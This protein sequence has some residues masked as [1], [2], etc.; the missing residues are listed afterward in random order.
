MLYNALIYPPLL[1]GITSWALTYSS[2][3]D[4][5]LALQN[6]FVKIIHFSDQ[7]DSLHPRFISSNMLKINELHKL[8]LASFVYESSLHQNPR[9][10]L[11][12]F[13]NIS[14]IHFY[15]TRQSSDQELFIPHKDTTQYGLFS[16]RYAGASLYNSIP[17]D[18]RS[19]PSVHSFHKNLKKHIIS[20]YKYL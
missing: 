1:Y 14:E 13:S 9:E 18:I 16:V 5:L 3:L 7:Y 10:F 19:R 8:Q 17:K 20:L 11:N 12:Y 6:K 15:A 4:A 2:S